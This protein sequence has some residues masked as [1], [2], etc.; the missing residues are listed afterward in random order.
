MASGLKATGCPKDFLI[1]ASLKNGYLTFNPI[2][3]QFH[4]K[5]S[6]GENCWP[7]ARYIFVIL[8][9]DLKLGLMDCSIKCVAEPDGVHNHDP[10]PRSLV[11]L[12]LMKWQSIMLAIRQMVTPANAMGV[13]Y[14]GWRGRLP[15]SKERTIQYFSRLATTGT[16]YSN[17]KSHECNKDVREKWLKNCGPEALAVALKFY[18]T[19][20]IWPRT[21]SQKAPL[22]N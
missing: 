11:S 5:S 20:L 7:C 22:G 3:G 13:I 1:C 14:D 2:T 18:K 19:T 10:P 17:Y 4:R 21:D 6:N 15:V 16:I 9:Q 12:L 8:D